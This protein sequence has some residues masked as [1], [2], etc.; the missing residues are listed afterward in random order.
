LLVRDLT[1]LDIKVLM[2]DGEHIADHCCV[3]ALAFTADGTK[4]PV[5]LW[6]GSTQNKTVVTHLLADLVSRG[7]DAKDGLLVVIDGAKALSSAVKAV[8]SV[9]TPRFSAVPS[10]NDGTL[11][12][13]C[14][15]P[16][17]AGSS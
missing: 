4:V 8:F 17:A 6:E 10:T 9:P 14:P 3:V 2:V 16:N 5:G 1:G 15:S 12:T 11:P 7:L 13:I